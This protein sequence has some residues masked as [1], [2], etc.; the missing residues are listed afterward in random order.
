[1]RGLLFLAWRRVWFDRVR[2][3]IL[4]LCLALAL[5]LPLATALLVA[6]HERELLARSDAT[7]LVAGAQQSRFDLVLGALTFRAPKL[8]PIPWSEFEALAESG[9][10]L[11]VPLHLGTSARGRPL[12]GTTPE[13]FELRGLELAQGTRPLVLGDVALGADVAR[14]LGLGPGDALPSDP[15][16]LYDLSRPASQRLTVCGVL[17]PSA[18]AD[19]GAGFVDVKTAWLLEGLIHGHGDASAL[20]ERLVLARAPGAVT[21]SGELVELQ[22]VT[23]ANQQSFHGH[24]D[25]GAAP[26]AAILVVPRDARAHTLLKARLN[27]SE[28]WQMV[29]PRA[30]VAELQGLVLRVKALLDGLFGLLGLSTLALTLLV[31]W[32]SARMRAPEA[33]MFERI[34]AARASLRWLQALEIAMIALLG[35]GLAL[36]ALVVASRLPADLLGAMR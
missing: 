3:G 14:E 24:A 1:M 29:E 5:F 11:C 4:A 35:A 13:Y 17:E 34:G 9:Q 19:D 31:L 25:P 36:V 20:D 15:R 16:E 10:A 2:C 7:P 23:P 30:V 18:S 22:E 28:R 8:A 27:A 32:L 33:R 26:L 6:R 12:V 21:L